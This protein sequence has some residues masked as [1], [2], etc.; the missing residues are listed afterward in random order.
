MKIYRNEEVACLDVPNRIK[1]YFGA[2]HE[3]R[4]LYEIENVGWI[5]K[6]EDKVKG[7]SF[8]M[9]LSK[10]YEGTDLEGRILLRNICDE[11]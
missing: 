7:I 6:T 9:F 11:L 2:G 8:D 3:N 5:I 1:W 10:K 4:T